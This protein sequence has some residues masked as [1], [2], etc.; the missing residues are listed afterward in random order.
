MTL[1]TVLLTR[2]GLHHYVTFSKSN[3]RN[4]FSIDG[5]MSHKMIQHAR[6]I[7]REMYQSKALV[8]VI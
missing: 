3:G 2:Y 7:I 5:L 8:Q 4:I 1:E 6:D